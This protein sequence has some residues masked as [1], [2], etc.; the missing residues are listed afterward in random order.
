MQRGIRKHPVGITGTRY[1]PLDNAHQIQEAV[2]KS[3]KAISMFTHP[4]TQALAAI[5]MVSYIQPFEDGNKRTARLMGNAI[6]VAHTVC[7]LSF[8]S[9]DESE[10]KKAI[11]LFYEQNNARPF[12][13]LFVNQFKFAVENYFRA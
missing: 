11:L 6:L 12:K 8:R 4:F 1:R 5:L 10:Y 13:E 7:P 3:L 2:K 9:V